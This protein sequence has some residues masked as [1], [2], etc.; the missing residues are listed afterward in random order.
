[1]VVDGT[2]NDQISKAAIELFS[3]LPQAKAMG[4]AGRQ[5]ITNEW[6][7]QIWSDKFE[8]LLRQ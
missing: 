3:D 2:N 8:A 6:R 1:V 5:W 4:A 7:W